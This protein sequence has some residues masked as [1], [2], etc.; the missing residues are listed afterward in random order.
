VG[1]NFTVALRS[2]QPPNQRVP[3]ALSL[4]IK[5]SGREADHSQPSS[6]HVKNAW[7]YTSTH[8]I[9]LPSWCG[10]KFKAQKQL[11]RYLYLYIKNGTDFAQWPYSVCDVLWCVKQSQQCTDVCRNTS[12]YVETYSLLTYLIHGAGYYLKICHSARQKISRSLME[13]EGSL[14]CS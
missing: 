5:R 10:D 6:A 1:G 9:R 2:T 14:T 8:P 3:G 13:P 12:R 7:S 11:Y 4:G